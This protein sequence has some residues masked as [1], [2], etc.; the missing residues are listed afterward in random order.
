MFKIILID[1]EIPALEEMSFLLSNYKNF[2]IVGFY[3]DPKKGIE[4]IE[5]LKPDV[6]FLDITMPEIDG[7]QV[8]SITM[9]FDNP[10]LIVFATAFDEY[11]VKAFEANATDY[12]LK[13]FNED[14]LK[15]IMERLEEKLSDKSNRSIELITNL[16]SKQNKS[17]KLPLWKNNRIY[18]VDKE[19]ILYC[20]V[21]SGETK[22]HTL[23][24]EYSTQENLN[25]LEKTLEPPNF[26][27]SHR[28]YII[29]INKI[30]EIIPWY[31]SSYVVKFQNHDEEVPVSRRNSKEFKD[32]LNL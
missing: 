30:S 13:P 19:N 17:K 8:A 6:I 5:N 14:R 9:D 31:G 22:I 2:E 28:N 21:I 18:L 26:F 10:P 24:E 20:S 23:N 4:A 16:L 11:A 12:I 25:N 3:S 27:R 29:H 32:L 15:I 1:D 7:F